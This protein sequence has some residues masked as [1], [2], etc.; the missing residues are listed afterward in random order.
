MS[1]SRYS[2]YS[3]P[4]SVRVGI[5]LVRV[6]LSLMPQHRAKAVGSQ[7]L[8]PHHEHVERG[9]LAGPCAARQLLDATGQRR[10]MR[11]RR[12]FGQPLAHACRSD[13]AGRDADGHVL[14]GDDRVAE[15]REEA[16]ARAA[17]ARLR[18]V[19]EPPVRAVERGHAL[20]AG[21]LLLF[22]VIRRVR[23]PRHDEHLADTDVLDAG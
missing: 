7:R 19:G 21:R 20:R 6:A 3:L 15:R 8:H 14:P 12:A 16:A 4:G 13:A 23:L 17:R 22:A 10:R 18:V 11:K 9:S 5:L 1:F 2:R